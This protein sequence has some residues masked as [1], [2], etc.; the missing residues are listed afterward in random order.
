MRAHWKPFAAGLAVGILLTGMF[1]ALGVRRMRLAQRAGPPM[2]HMLRFL[3][4]RLELA[5]EQR[6]AVKAILDDKRRKL[7]A[8]RSEA[9]PR[10]E[11]LRLEGR[12]E[13]RAVLR[14]DQQERFDRL[15]A[16]W[17][18]RRRRMGPPPPPMP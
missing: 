2:E 3:G 15:E 5:P 12:R 8:M 13:I 4:R 16:D 11:A 7:D 17:E 18:K 10:F 9:E 1:F 14:P 6:D